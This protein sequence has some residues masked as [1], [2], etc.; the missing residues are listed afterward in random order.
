[1]A[2]GGGCPDTVLLHAAARPSGSMKKVII[3]DCIV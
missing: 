2:A 1:M 3:R